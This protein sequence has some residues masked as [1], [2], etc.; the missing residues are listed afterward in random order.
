MQKECPQYRVDGMRFDLKPANILVNANCELAVCD[1]GS[2]P[3]SFW[4][5]L[6]GRGPVAPAAA[7]PSWCA[8]SFP[9]RLFLCS[10][11]AGAVAFDEV[12]DFCQAH[13]E[14]ASVYALDLHAALFVWVGARATAADRELALSHGIQY[15]F[16]R[17]HEDGE[18]ESM[19][20]LPSHLPMASPRAP[21]RPPTRCFAHRL[22]HPSPT[23]SATR[24]R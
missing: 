22:A 18:R 9:P 21:L 24:E 8:Q 11:A 4:T 2:E 20:P 23:L 17:S 14:Q 6:G 19:A 7:Q 3:G 13:L 10:A 12:A 15:Q 16:R 5:A 1:E